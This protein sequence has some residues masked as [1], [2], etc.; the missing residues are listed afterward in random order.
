MF[1]PYITVNPHTILI[2]ALNL[3]DVILVSAERIVLVPFG[4]TNSIG[5]IRQIYSV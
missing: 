2:N 1:Y 5:L 3:G 4:L